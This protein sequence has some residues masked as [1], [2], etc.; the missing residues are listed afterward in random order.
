MPSA[1]FILQSVGVEEDDWL[2]GVPVKLSAVYKMKIRMK[3]GYVKR[4]IDLKD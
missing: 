4:A 1:Y 2:G 3:N